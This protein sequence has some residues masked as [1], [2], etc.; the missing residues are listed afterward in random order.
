[1]AA[2]TG[3]TAVL[4]GVR[5]LIRRDARRKPAVNVDVRI[6]VATIVV[7]LVLMVVPAIVAVAELTS[8]PDR[9]LGRFLADLRAVCVWVRVMGCYPRA[10][11]PGL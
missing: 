2:A 5:A 11:E 10:I 1:M 9:G 3:L 6:Q 8:T 4:L 7:V